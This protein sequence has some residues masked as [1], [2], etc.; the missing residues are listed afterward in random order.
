VLGYNVYKHNDSTKTFTKINAQLITGTTFTDSCLVYQ[1]IQTYMLRALK[2]ETTP[3]GTFYNLS[4]GIF[5]TLLNPLNKI[6][7]AD[8]NF[9]PNLF[10][11]N[12]TNTSQNAA[13]YFWD[14]GDG[15]TST[16]QNPIHTYNTDNSYNVMLVANYNCDGTDTVYKTI[17]IATGIIKNNLEINTSIFPNPA[18]ESININTKN[19]SL[20]SII[21][22]NAQG[23]IIYEAKTEIEKNDYIIPVTSFA[24]GFYFI[25]LLDNNGN[26]LNKKIVI[27]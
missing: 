18:K 5:D 13:Y 7:V 22:L 16:Q 14:F 24:K 26:L 8:F 17:T 6:V 20:Q 12:F 27:E 3:S 2:Y 15:N 23:K 1:G 9:A 25:Q 10:Q 11:V 19:I 4:T 21:L